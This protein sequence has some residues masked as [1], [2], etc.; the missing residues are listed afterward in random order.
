MCV[1]V[2]VCVQH[3]EAAG[4][5]AERVQPVAQGVHEA[6]PVDERV[7]LARITAICLYIYI[8]I[9]IYIYNIYGCM[10]RYA[11]IR[12]ILNIGVFTYTQQGSWPFSTAEAP[13]ERE[14]C[15]LAPPVSAWAARR[16]RTSCRRPD[17]LRR[18]TPRPP[19][20][21]PVQGHGPIGQIG[22]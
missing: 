12:R 1:C 3:L 13:P 22:S 15:R 17:R 2:C 21:M 16:R 4:A 19:R 18:G 11:Q 14:A 7:R 20:A 6:Q 8:Y 10:G 5:A 9:Y